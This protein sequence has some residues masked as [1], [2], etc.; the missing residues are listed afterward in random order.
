MLEINRLADWLTDLMNRFRAAFGVP[1]VHAAAI[2]EFKPCCKYK[3]LWIQLLLRFNLLPTLRTQQH[4]SD[5]APIRLV[6][7]H[8]RHVCILYLQ[9][10]LWNTHRKVLCSRRQTT[11]VTQPDLHLT[12]MQHVSC[13]QASWHFVLLL[14]PALISPVCRVVS[15]SI[16]AR[17]FIWPYKRADTIV[18]HQMKAT[19][20]LWKILKV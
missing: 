13:W 20:T 2:A 9:M 16:L 3:I 7:L 18:L 8:L 4:A 12:D 11:V 17:M 14:L 10:N 15:A 19:E 1:N 6:K 5:D